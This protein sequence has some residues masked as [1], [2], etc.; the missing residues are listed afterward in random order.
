[1]KSEIEP[2]SRR[3]ANVIIV[4]MIVVVVLAVA[5][6]FAVLLWSASVSN[7]TAKQSKQQLVTG[8]MNVLL[9]EHAR[10]QQESA[11][12]DRTYIRAA[13]GIEQKQWLQYNIG[14]RL[15]DSDSFQKSLILD[16]AYQP[17]MQFNAEGD[18]AFYTPH[19]KNQIFGSVA[20]VRAR[21]ILEFYED[22]HRSPVSSPS[23]HF[24]QRFIFDT[25]YAEMDGELFLYSAA[26]IRPETAAFPAPKASPAVLISFRRFDRDLAGTVAR[27]TGVKNL[28]LTFSQSP[29]PEQASIEIR[30]VTGRSIAHIT[31]KGERPGTALLERLAPVLLIL[32][33]AIIGL[34][35]GVIDFT[36][37]TTQ[38]LETNQATAL[39]NSR[40][41][42][43]SG[44]PNRDE[45]FD[46]LRVAL[47]EE[48]PEATQT[49]VVYIDLDRFKDINDT[50]GHAAG[51]TVICAVA[52]RLSSVLPEK[53]VLARISGD[54]F[55]MFLP[56]CDDPE[57]VEMVL[58]RFQDCLT[59]P[60]TAEHT[61]IHVSL[62]M[63]AALAPQDGN[64]PGELM[65]KADIALYD[66]K[67]SGRS[68][69][70]FF[71]SSM[72]EQVLAKDKLSRE[73]RHAIDNDLLDV[74][75]QPQISHDGRQVTSLEALAR[76]RHPEMGAISPVRFI[77]LAE[78]TGLINDLGMWILR[79]ACRDADQWP[80]L[81]IAVNVSPS[82]FK[83][84]RFVEQVLE[85]LETFSIPP[86]RLEIEVTESVFA[87]DEHAILTAMKRLKD[88][89]V[90][91][92]LDDFGSGYSSLSYLRK[93]PFD[94]LKIDRC[95]LTAFDD[96]AEA[97][98]IVKT[99]IALGKA[100][101]MEIVG[102]GVETI[103]QL[104]FL[105]ENGCDRIQGYFIAVPLTRPRLKEFLVVHAEDIA[106]QKHTVSNA[107]I[108]P[109][110]HK[111][112]G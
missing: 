47:L 37:Q 85:T 26:A 72:Q 6:V 61:E 64:S 24:D 15:Y 9:M 45:F 7:E 74:A 81:T 66:A 105:L 8:T 109:K 57:R 89:G 58:A 75:Y 11:L 108:S 92:A 31:W 50:L 103:E 96:G 2:S 70:S 48:T 77:P 87:S 18:T 20:R 107:Q 54:E 30:N 41:D 32:A 91:I 36:R 40:H 98:A 3:I 29:E 101:G 27:L 51:D 99:I 93:F 73:L 79:R 110:V 17:L 83:H 112:L 69:W 42:T 16:H 88:L 111:L 13:K 76:W 21:T 19:V 106:A 86:Q 34:T 33:L 67:A 80:H 59:R 56:G 62:S 12:S 102:E 60:V 94:T 35:I 1:M 53:G 100:L 14:Q 23:Q 68:R 10:R 97:R 65:R 71:S 5:G 4:P 104:D 39:Y 49:A 44:L 25:G 78:E 28:R 46:L 95:F 52:N 82:Q 22:N 38:K 90:K 84:P 43:L 63:G 55:A